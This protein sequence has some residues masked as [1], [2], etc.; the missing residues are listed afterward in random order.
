MQENFP[1]APVTQTDGGHFL[2]E[3]VPAEI[4]EALIK[5]IDK[6]NNK[7]MVLINPLQD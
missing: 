7:D 4:A 6:V 1:K 3:E 5:V 2:Q